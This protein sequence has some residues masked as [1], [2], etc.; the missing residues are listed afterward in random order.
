[1]VDEDIVNST[2]GPGQ[3][4]TSFLEGGQGRVTLPGDSQPQREGDC[5]G[6]LP[7][8]SHLQEGDTESD[9]GFLERRQGHGRHDS[10]NGRWETAGS[11]RADFSL[12]QDRRLESRGEGQEHSES[13]G[14]ELDKYDRGQRRDPQLGVGA[15]QRVPWGSQSDIEGLYLKKEGT[16]MWGDCLDVTE[17]RGNLRKERGA[18]AGSGNR[19]L[20]REAPGDNGAR[21]PCVPEFLGAHSSKAGMGPECWGIQAGGDTGHGEAGVYWGAGGYPGQTSAGNGTQKS[22]L[23]GDR[24]LLGYTSPE[25]KAEGSFQN[26]GGHG[27][28]GRGYKPGPE[29]PEDLR[30][31]K[32]GLQEFQ[33]RNGQGSAGAL[34]RTGEGSRS[35]Q[36]PQS[37]TVG[38]KGAGRPGGAEYENIG[39]Q[40]DTW[41][42][43]R[44]SG[45]L[46][47]GEKEG[48]VGS[49]QVAALV[50]SSQR[51]DARNHGLVTSPGLGVQGSGGTRGHMEALRDPRAVGSEEEFLNVSGRSQG[52]GSRG[53][54][55]LGGPE[56]AESRNKEGWE[57]SE[58]MASRNGATC[59]GGSGRPEGTGSGPDIGC[60]ATCGAPVETESG[61]WGTY[62]HDSGVP[63]GLWSGNKGQRGPAGKVSRREAGLRTGSGGLHGMPSSEAQQRD[64]FQ[65]HGQTGH[66]EEH[67]CV[68]GLGSSGT[69]GSVSEHGRKD[70]GTAGKVGEGYMEAEPGHSGGLSSWG[71]TGD[72]EDFR[73]LGAFR[74]G[75]FGNGTGVPLSMG[76]GSLGRGDKEGDGERI[77]FLGARSSTVGTGNWDKARHPGAPFP[78]AE[79]SSEGH[80]AQ[81]SG[82]AFGYRDRSGIPEPWSAGDKTAHGEESKGLGPERT[83]PDGEVAFRDSSLG[84][85]GMGL[86]SEASYKSGTWSSVAVDSGS[87]VDYKNDLGCSEVMGS[88]S[89]AGYKNNI[90]SHGVRELEGPTG[91]KNGLGPSEL[92]SSRNEAGGL[93]HRG[94]VLSL[95]KAGFRVGL[96]GTGRMESKNGVGYRGSS[97]EPGKVGS[98]RKMHLADGSGRLRGRGSLA[99]P[100]EHDSVGLGSVCEG[101]AEIGIKDS[102]EK[103]RGMGLRDATGPEVGSG[104]AG[105]LDT[106]G[107]IA[108]GD[109]VMGPEK[110][111]TPDRPHIFSGGQGTKNSLGGCV[112]LEIPDA[113]GAVGSVGKP[114]I[115][116]WKDDSGFQGSLRDRGTPSEEIKCVDQAGAIGTSRLLDSRG[117]MEDGSGPGLAALESEHDFDCNKS[118]LGTTGRCRVAGQQGV[119]P[120]GCGGSLLNGRRRGTSSGSLSGV[121]QAVDRSSTPGRETKV[122]SG[123]GSGRAMSHTQ[124]ADWEEQVQGSFGVSSSLQD[125]NAIF[126]E[127]HE[128]QGAFK[129]RGCE[130]GQGP[131]AE[132]QGPRSLESRGSEFV[133]GRAGFIGSSSVPGRRDSTIYRDGATSKP[134]EP[135][136]GL[137][138]SL[139]RRDFESTSGGIQEPGFQRGTGQGKGKESLQESGSWEAEFDKVRGTRASGKFENQG[140]KNPGWSGRKPGLCESRHQVQCGTEVGSAKRATPEGARG[141]EPRTGSEDRGSLREPWSEDRRQGPHRHLGSRRDTQEGRSDVCGQ[142]QDATQ[143]P[144][145]RYQPGTGRSSSEARGRY[146][147]L[148][149]LIGWSQRVESLDTGVPTCQ[150]YL[151]HRNSPIPV[152]LFPRIPCK[153]REPPLLSSPCAEGIR[154]M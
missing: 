42:N 127:T 142:A 139:G 119:T 40:D 10:E 108:H 104:V 84:L 73:V 77:S 62:S 23:S 28:V 26:T 148:V 21:S 136:D 49:S 44:E 99:A 154:A 129:G 150:F 69:V 118:C 29:D 88:E 140:G 110:L 30:N 149:A 146:S 91:Y 33:G 124:A 52:K 152:S 19:A 112:S 15:G 65:G 125:T 135:Q 47:S 22:S 78:H 144:R 92:I 103:V 83:G 80:W 61:K 134:Q 25:A 106:T 100:K 31:Q 111:G 50:M 109:S 85:R 87:K 45:V 147:Q 24:K 86:A 82:N 11:P 32:G 75:D 98:E 39:P 51:V 59:P 66:V 145:S 122:M 3:D 101:A 46:G 138:S 123:P 102:G 128:G 4:K 16:E 60:K 141:L 114:G 117:T 1:M 126:R 54:M 137:Y 76:P 37:W 115:R 143:S 93:E 107:G 94:D 79:A 36:F 67:H 74:E 34:G 132:S 81:V 72:Y 151:Q 58:G 130:T 63:G 20:L 53:G 96:G 97:A 64:V 18:A 12:P 35:P 8:K 90:E 120:Q 41:S 56:W 89:K 2:W 95:N 38:Q 71:H 13:Y 57:Y 7:R 43:L 131:A 133:G 17:G 6:S 27:I 48:S 113:L 68:R 153:F 5:G 70:S 14:S 105:M 121:G 55:G 9:S 116:E